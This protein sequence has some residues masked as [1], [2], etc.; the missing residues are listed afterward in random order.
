MTDK[1]EAILQAAMELF[2]ERG[3]HGTPVPMIVE[4]ANVS[5]GTMYRYF[6][7][8]EELVNVL[9]RHWKLEMV[10]ATIEGLPE[11]LPLRQLFHEI[12]HR[13]KN[14]ALD[15]QAAYSFLEAHH[16]A[17]YLDEESCALTNKLHRRYIEF[18]ERGRRE[19]IVKDVAPEMLVAVVAGIMIEIM[20]E[21]W[22]GWFELTPDTVAQA[23]EICWEAVRR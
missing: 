22:A 14:F 23:E 17:P 8:K 6:R 9:Y 19:Q 7:D 20:K 12:W 4:K 11:D 5:T 18:F 16:H 1:R 10:K 13:W 2:S 15:H 3:F 21:H